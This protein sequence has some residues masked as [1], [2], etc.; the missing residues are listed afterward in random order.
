MPATYQAERMQC[1]DERDPERPAQSHG[2]DARHEEVGVS[3]VV[4]AGRGRD[5]FGVA[6]EVRHA[7]KQPFLGHESRWPGR[8]V[9]HA[10][11][12]PRVQYRCERR[13]VA[14]GEDID[15]MPHPGQ[16]TSDVV[17]IDVL[18][19]GL[20]AP[21]DGQRRCV[22]TDQRDSQALARVPWHAAL[23]A[24]HVPLSGQ[25]PERTGTISWVLARADSY[26]CEAVVARVSS[27]LA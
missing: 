2:D 17:H 18:A 3:D 11:A 27:R 1:D 5:R 9:D 15:V 22:L 21:G 26:S 6:R 13:V 19:A 4:A 20:N 8:H 25:F 24:N 12:G 16:F 23:K 7:G 10:H 14:P